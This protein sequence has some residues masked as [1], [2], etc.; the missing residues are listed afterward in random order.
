MLALGMASLPLN[1]VGSEYSLPVF[2]RWRQ[3]N[4]V[5]CAQGCSCAALRLQVPRLEVCWNPKSNDYPLSFTSFLLHPPSLSEPVFASVW[6]STQPLLPVT[7]ERSQNR[8]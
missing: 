1:H 3:A 7:V 2:Y 5:R 6:G 4:R 8:A